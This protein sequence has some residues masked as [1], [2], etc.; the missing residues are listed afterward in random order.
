MK[1]VHMHQNMSYYTETP[2][3]GNSVVLIKNTKFFYK[4]LGV[5]IE[6]SDFNNAY[7]GNNI[8]NIPQLMSTATTT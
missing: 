5:C 3:T 6:N 8:I 4:N 2:T 1:V 7:L